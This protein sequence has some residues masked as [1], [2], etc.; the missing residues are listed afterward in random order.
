MAAPGTATSS[1]TRALLLDEPTAALDL[2]QQGAALAFA[3]RAARDGA[4]VLAVLHDLNQ[5]ASADC[6][7]LLRAGRLVA[8]G[9]ASAVMQPN[10]MRACFGIDVEMVRRADGRVAF[11]AA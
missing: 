11:L 4:A 7:V 3:R 1:A 10:A 5:A 6:V 8:A 9:S 2:A